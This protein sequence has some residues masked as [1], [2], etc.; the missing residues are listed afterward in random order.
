MRSTTRLERPVQNSISVEFRVVL[1]EAART[2][3]ANGCVRSVD[4]ILLA[5]LKDAV[6]SGRWL[7]PGNG[8]DTG[9]ASLRHARH[10]KTTGCRAENAR[11]LLWQMRRSR[12]GG[13]CTAGGHCLCLGRKAGIPLHG[14]RQTEEVCPQSSFSERNGA[15]RAKGRQPISSERR[16]GASSSSTG[17]TTPATRW[18][19]MGR[20][21]R[22]ICFPRGFFRPDAFP[23]SATGWLW[24]S[25][26]SSRR[27]RSLNRGESTSPSCG[28]QPMRMSSPPFARSSTRSASE[29]WG[30]AR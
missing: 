30:R 14:L 8:G 29:V 11:P 24:T 6:N 15:T 10:I 16:R 9:Q 18:W 4:M 22:C 3:A 13:P 21:S 23:S 12:R 25:A 20:S 17:A 19:S 2:N 5:N 26:F 28:F 27:S 7:A 1:P